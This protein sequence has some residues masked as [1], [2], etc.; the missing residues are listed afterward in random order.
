MS[1]EAKAKQ[2]MYS[3]DALTLNVAKCLIQ[4]FRTVANDC[5][6]Y[7]DHLDALQSGDIRAIRS[8]TPAVD[9]N[10]ENPFNVKMD[11]QIASTL[12]RYR[13]KEDLYTDE[14]LREQAIGKFV[15][16]Q[17]RLAALEDVPVNVYTQRVLQGAQVYIRLLLGEF[18]YDEHSRSC[19]FGRRASVG[20]KAREACEAARWN[21]PISGSLEQIRWFDSEMSQVSCVQE[22]WAKQRGS[23]PKRSTY[24][25]CSSLKLTL[26]PKTFKSY[27]VIMPNTTIGSY[28][29]YGIGVMLRKRLKAKGYDISILQ[30]THKSLAKSASV[31][32]MYTTLDLSSASDTISV[33][34][35]EYLFPPDWFEIM[36]QSRIGHVSIPSPHATAQTFD[37]IE[38]LTFG[39]MGVGYTFPLQTLVFLSI[40]KSIWAIENGRCRATISVYG[41][42]MI[43]PSSMYRKVVEVFEEVGFM[44]N[45]DKT[46]HEGYFRE[47]CGGDYHRGVDVRPFQPQNGSAL[48][49]KISYEAVLYKYINTL[50]M[51][52]DQYVVAGTIQYLLSE[53]RRVVGAV[54]LVPCDYPDDSGL[55][56]PTLSHWNFIQGVEIAKLKSLGNGSYRFPYLRFDALVRKEARHEPYL[57]LALREQCLD[58]DRY[59]RGSDSA[60][61]PNLFVELR[62][63][64]TIDANRASLQELIDNQLL[65]KELVRLGDAPSVLIWLKDENHTVR[66]I[67]GRRLRRLHAHTTVSGYGRYKRQSG[68][69]SFEDRRR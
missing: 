29:T 58:V 61:D 39:T 10:M 22:Y 40:L 27:R 53:I 1:N 18:D 15:G 50:L 66:D 32:G 8:T 46:Y 43:F 64:D 69:S 28:M 3:A 33:S 12:K 4:D 45:I 54:K 42:D 35:V 52:W 9:V 31:H 34:L 51:R 62:K 47:S 63:L 67:S 20:V 21:L 41:D 2:K 36:N 59:D 49:G 26:V 65:I 68:I 11:Y 16:V 56:C 17:H 57:W 24:Q 19:R 13:I 7:S 23:D 55:K 38:S 6:L 37:C 60:W 44:I 14:E 5:T 25:R 48:V 30:D